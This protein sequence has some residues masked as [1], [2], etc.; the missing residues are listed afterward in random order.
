LHHQGAR[1]LCKPLFSSIFCDSDTANVLKKI[2]RKCSCRIPFSACQE[3]GIGGK[4][5]KNFIGDF[6]FSWYRDL[7]NVF[8][9]I[10][11][12]SSEKKQLDSTRNLALSNSRPYSIEKLVCTKRNEHLDMG[13]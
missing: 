11:L 13:D 10:V 5:Q 1:E 12:L 8:A 6:L 4:N 9:R 2:S 7:I 3:T